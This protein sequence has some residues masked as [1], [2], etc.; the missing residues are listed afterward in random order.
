MR[1]SLPDHPRELPAGARRLEDRSGDGGLRAGT[2]Y[3]EGSSP[4][5]EPG[6]IWPAPSGLQ[7]GECG[8][9]GCGAGR[10]GNSL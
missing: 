3:H 7:S 10:K 5:P 6:S 1:S 9:D 8:S 4:S 2:L